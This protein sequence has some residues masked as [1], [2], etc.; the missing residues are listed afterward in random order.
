MII[1]KLQ[2]GLGNQLFQ[3]AV[4]RYLSFKYSTALKFDLYEFLNPSQ[5]NTPR[6]FKLKH[7]NIC[8][9]VAS[10]SDLDNDFISPTLKNQIMRRIEIFLGFPSNFFLIQEKS[11]KFDPNILQTPDNCYLDGYWG[12]EKYFGHIDKVI[13]NELRIIEPIDPINLKYLEK[14]TNGNSVSIHVR[15]GD[16]V[17]IQTN[18]Q[19]H[20]V[21]SLKYYSEAIDYIANKVEKPIFYIFSDD[22]EWCMSNI[23]VHYPV[24]YITHNGEEKDYED[25][26]LLS[27]CKHH[28]IANSTFSWWGAWLG[29]DPNKIVIAPKKWL[30]IEEKLY[31]DVIPENWIQI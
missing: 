22:S 16:F 26:R 10:L 9:E 11:L 19:F 20:G 2:G 5:N 4:G 31:R 17:N 21:C 13:R 30:M 23:N 18:L 8:G 3:Y 25:F 1:V 27:Q 24:T 12:S 7:F 28:I 6:T 29:S 14:I 15:R